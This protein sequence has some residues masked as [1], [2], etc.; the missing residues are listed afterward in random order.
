VFPVAILRDVRSVP[1]VPRFK[2]NE[3]KNVAVALVPAPAL[4]KPAADNQAED[5]PLRLDESEEMTIS[6]DYDLPLA[7]FKGD[8]SRFSRGITD[9]TF[10]KHREMKG[11][12]NV[13]VRIFDIPRGELIASSKE[14]MNTIEKRG[15]RVATFLELVAYNRNGPKF[16]DGWMIALGSV[17]KDG[18]VP[19]TEIFERD[20]FKEMS[21][22]RFSELWTVSNRFLAVKE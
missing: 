20:G 14:V 5:R 12:K 16:Q 2:K 10:S 6:V 8:Y 21:L 13:V 4:Q 18:Y 9:D 19:K 3:P 7:E 22:Q 1:C 15:Y 17:T 11:K